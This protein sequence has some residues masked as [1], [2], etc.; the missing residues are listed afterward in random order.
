MP[1]VRPTGGGI[2]RKLILAGGGSASSRGGK[3]GN[4]I[5]GQ[6]LGASGTGYWE[7]QSGDLSDD[8]PDHWV[9]VRADAWWLRS[10]RMREIVHGMPP[11]LSRLWPVKWVW[12]SSLRLHRAEC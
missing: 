7:Q 11:G 4:R 9:R 5:I 10:G 1:S 2:E 3:K 6:G 8:V 12:Y